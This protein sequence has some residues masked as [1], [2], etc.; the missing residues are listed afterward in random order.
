SRSAR[1]AVILLFYAVELAAV[2]YLSYEL[3]WDF[4]TPPDEQLQRATLIIPIVLC[5]LLLL[6]SFGQFRS[7]FSY[8]GLADFGGVVVAISTV[9]AMMLGLW[10]FSNVTAAPPRGVI[11][12][13]FVLSVSLISAFRLSLRVA[14]TWSVAGV[15]RK[16]HDRKRVAIIGAGD[17][18]EALAKDLLQ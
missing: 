15:A 3:R 6:Q 12:M 13:D 7:V 16:P 9:S 17:L 2:F 5:K 4:A 11:L 10:Y 1:V 18:G 8:F 14:R